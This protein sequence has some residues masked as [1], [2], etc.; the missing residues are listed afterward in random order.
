MVRTID[1]S[2]L[3]NVRLCNA[4]EVA[5]RDEVVKARSAAAVAE[6]GVAKPGQISCASQQRLLT[7]YRTRPNHE[8]DKF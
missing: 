1:G 3:L 4:H 6:R 5:C 2:E 8:G 7:L